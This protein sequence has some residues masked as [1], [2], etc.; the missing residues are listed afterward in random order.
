MSVVDPAQT[1]RQEA[2]ELLEQLEQTLLDL[3]HAPTDGDLID[4][5]L[6]VAPTPQAR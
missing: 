3:E 2:Q 5:A 6:V 1:F 4:T